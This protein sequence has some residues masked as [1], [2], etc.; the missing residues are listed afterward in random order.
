MTLPSVIAGQFGIP[1]LD[2]QRVVA[3]ATTTDFQNRALQVL[4]F[5][6]GESI[7]LSARSGLG[8]TWQ[9]FRQA[10]DVAPRSTDVFKV[11]CPARHR[12]ALRG[13]LHSDEVSSPEML[14][15]EIQHEVAIYHGPLRPLQ[16]S[17]VSQLVAV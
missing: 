5:G 2:L 11:C 17:L 14:R 9:V 6:T 7:C 13:V 4:P 15:E 16:G 1:L 3:C 8:A 12:D 10:A